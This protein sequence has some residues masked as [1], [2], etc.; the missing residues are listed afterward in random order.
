M[1]TITLF[2]L[3]VLL[4]LVLRYNPQSKVYRNRAGDTITEERLGPTSIRILF[5]ANRHPW[6]LDV[7]RHDVYNILCVSQKH[8]FKKTNKWY[9]WSSKNKMLILY[10]LHF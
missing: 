8:L 7:T 3:D 2:C 4:R 5:A 1:K 6:L 10:Q 9:K